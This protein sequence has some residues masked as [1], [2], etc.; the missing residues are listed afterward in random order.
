MTGVIDSRFMNI[1]LAFGL[2]TRMSKDGHRRD[3]K[4]C[5]NDYS[6]AAINHLRSRRLLIVLENGRYQNFDQR[7]EDEQGAD[8]KEHVEPRHVR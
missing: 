1:E 4:D 7:K 2:T 3:N 8:E 6:A 5:G